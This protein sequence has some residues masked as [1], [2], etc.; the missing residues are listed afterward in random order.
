MPLFRKVD[1]IL[2]KLYPAFFLTILFVGALTVVSLSAASALMTLSPTA[3]I[4]VWGPDIKI[5]PTEI[6]VPNRS[7]QRNFDMVANPANPQM[8]FTS[9]DNQRESTNR[10][11][12]AV[13]TD[14][15]Q[16]WNGGAFVD[17]WE[18]GHLPLGDTNVAAN[19]QGVAYIS[20]FAQSPNSNGYFV[21]S[22]TNGLNWSTP[23]PI[24][25]TDNYSFHYKTQLSVDSS[26]TSPYSGRLY[27][28][29]QLSN[30][31][32]P[33]FQG[34]KLQYSANGGVSWSPEI[35]VADPQWYYAAYGASAAV[36]KDGTAYLAYTNIENNS[37]L[38][39]PYR[40]LIDR[41]TDGGVTWGTDR[42]ITG[43]PMVHIGR[44]DFKGGR[45]L[46]LVADDKCSIMRIFNHPFIA[47][48][49]A[50]SDTVYAVWNDGRWDSVFTLCG[51]S[52]R[53]SDIAFSRSTDGGATWSAPVRLNDDTQGNGVDQ[54]QP[55]IAVREDGLIGVTWLDRRYSTESQYFYDVA[56]TQSTDGGLTW[57]PN[58]RVTDVSNDPDPVVDYKGVDDLGY[59]NSLVF[60][61]NYVVPTW[62]KTVLGT[63]NGDYYI[64]RGFIKAVTSS[65]TPVGTSTRTATRTATTQP[66]VTGTATV[67]ATAT[68]CTLQFS[69]VDGQNP[70]YQNI[71]CL[72]C[73]GII[74]GYA[75]GTFR[76]NN[77][78]TRGQIAKMVSNAAGF[79][80]PVGGQSFE[81][82]APGSTFYE[83]IERLSSR[84]VMGGYVCGG[85]GEPCV[86]PQNRP[87]F[88]AGLNATRGQLSKIVSNAAGYVEPHTG[89]FYADVTAGNPFYGEIMRLTT[90]GAM[91]GYPC[92]GVGEP[93]DTE[94]RPYF[95]WGNP[96]TR[97]QAS[98]IV[99]N[100]FYPG[101][102]TP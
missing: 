84:G 32:P 39:G 15:G 13:S 5:N 42:V 34:V 77:N 37:F 62:I 86:P 56:Y 52:G 81:D 80:E 83:W 61:G 75:D 68:T 10:S 24:V 25:V 90:R 49:P 71:R 2:R 88:R 21:L 101:C 46:V 73:R 94:Q 50:D 87:Y 1:L 14:S 4:P 66:A 48:S 8:L 36:A 57:S 82:V 74:S 76:P 20:S 41:S 17:T 19:G 7:V 63:F 67:Q 91:S 12:Y 33:F 40:L 26:T 27:F 92:G 11:A 100:T 28:F 72:S 29:S 79:T 97:G 53:H 47:V 93:C 23:V 43:A 55:S 89:Q 3:T 35:N 51:D 99:A 70:F 30:N 16:T 45:E 6:P 95:R 58:Q 78:I 64:D 85:A 9:Y 59:K 98:K 44:P 69:D 54:F 18:G 22:S 96:V 60:A 38:N 65:P 31:I 102:Q